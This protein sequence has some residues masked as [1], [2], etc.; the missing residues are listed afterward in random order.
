MHAEDE[1][2]K[3]LHSG[4]G[5]FMGS[6]RCR[7]PDTSVHLLLLRRFFEGPARYVSHTWTLRLQNE[8]LRLGIQKR[9]RK[10]DGPHAHWPRLSGT[11]SKIELQI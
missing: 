9:L 6:G 8:Y 7:I 3:A 1:P 2:W 10:S 11:Y 5:I 4:N